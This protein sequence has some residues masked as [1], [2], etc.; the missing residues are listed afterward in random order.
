MGE[1]AIENPLAPNDATPHWICEKLA[2][3]PTPAPPPTAQTPTPTMPPEAPS[4]GPSSTC[5]VET[6]WHCSF[7]TCQQRGV[8]NAN[9]HSY[10]DGVWHHAHC[11]CDPGYCFMKG[12]PA[13]S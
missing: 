5:A 10:W 4:G 12:K 8:T 2:I 7:R 6:D 1:P 9:C 3:M 13:G 11:Q